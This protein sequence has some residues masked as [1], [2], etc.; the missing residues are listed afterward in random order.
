[1]LQPQDRKRTRSRVRVHHA[2]PSEGYYAT[3]PAG[4]LVGAGWCYP[5]D[6]TTATPLSAA[7]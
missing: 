3:K 2:G 1:M 4:P 5:I 6:S 7:C